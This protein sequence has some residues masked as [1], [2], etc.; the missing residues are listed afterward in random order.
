VVP[1]KRYSF[2]YL[3]DLSSFSN[4]IDAWVR[5]SR[6][7]SPGQV[8][9]YNAHAVELDRF[10]AWAGA[11]TDS[12]TLLRYVG[13]RAAIDV[14]QSALDTYKDSHCWVFTPTHFLEVCADLAALGLMEWR[15]AKFVDTQPNELDFGVVLERTIDGDTADMAASFHAG[16]PCIAR[17]KAVNRYA[18]T[19]I[20]RL[21]SE[22]DAVLASRSWRLTAPLRWLSRRARGDLAP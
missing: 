8:F 2:D 19:E 4:M 5:K 14:S 3:W 22:L 10:A 20:D 12:S 7:P 9:D 21:R 1:E 16:I 13:P 15:L 6:K 17:C 18:E 11:I